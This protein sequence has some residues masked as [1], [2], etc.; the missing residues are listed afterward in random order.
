MTPEHATRSVEFVVDP[1][2]L[3]AEMKEDNERYRRG[4]SQ[5][6]TV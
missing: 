6:A 3:A 1:T 4:F 2:W 5:A